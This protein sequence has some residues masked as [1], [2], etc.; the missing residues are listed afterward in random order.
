MQFANELRVLPNAL[1]Q[2]IWAAS[3]NSA[4]LWG[5]QV[6]TE[7][8]FFSTLASWGAG[9]PYLHGSAKRLLFVRLLSALNRPI[10][11]LARVETLVDELRGAAVSA[12]QFREAVE[13]ALSPSSLER[14]RFFLQL[15]ETY[16]KE[17][18]VRPDLDRA[19]RLAARKL[20]EGEVSV[21]SDRASI[22]FAPLQRLSWHKTVVLDALAR[23]LAPREVRIEVPHWETQRMEEPGAYSR[24][25][26]AAQPASDLLLGRLE[27]L[28]ERAAL[29]VLPA[30][31]EARPT[32]R[33]VTTHQPQSERVQV[34]NKLR[35][36]LAAGTPPHRI[37]VLVPDAANLPLWEQTMARAGVR[38]V[39][40]QK[41]LAHTAWGSWFLCLIDT[42]ARSAPARD[43]VLTVLES[44]F[45]EGVFAGARTS[46]GLLRRAH[47]RGHAPLAWDVMRAEDASNGALDALADL[48]TDFRQARS[49]AE[50]HAWLDRLISLLA[51]APAVR[52]RQDWLAVLCGDDAL[53]A[54]GLQEHALVLKSVGKVID[55]FGLEISSA[56]ERSVMEV[57]SDAIYAWLTAELEAA[58]LPRVNTERGVHVVTISELP[59][60][61]VDLLIATGL[62]DDDFPGTLAEESLLSR[63][64]RAEIGR[65]LATKHKGALWLFD[66]ASH[67]GEPAGHTVELARRLGALLVATNF[68]REALWSR[69]RADWEG[70]SL[71]PSRIWHAV[72]TYDV[73]DADLPS[74]ARA[75]D[76]GAQLRAEREKK[77]LKAMLH[78][79]TPFERDSVPARTSTPLHFSAS[80]LEDVVACRFRYF[81]KHVLRV[82]D[83]E[84]A[85]EDL[86]R[87]FSGQLAHAAFERLVRLL[88]QQGCVPFEPARAQ[89]AIEIASAS[90]DEILGNLDLGPAAGRVYQETALLRQRLLALVTA[91]YD[92]GEGFSPEWVEQSFGYD[93]ENSW[94]ALHVRTSAGDAFVRGRIDLVERRGDSFRVTDLKSSGVGTLDSK[95]GPKIGERELQLPIYCA[96]TAEHFG[97]RDIDGR[98]LSLRDSGITR[99]LRKK[100]GRGR[101]RG[102]DVDERVLMRNADG[103]ETELAANLQS[104]VGHV[105]RAD[106]RVHPL[107]GACDF[108]DYAAACRFPRGA[109]SREEGSS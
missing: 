26:H 66:L 55:A 103:E 46:A 17:C 63:S 5:Q 97:T 61:E 59:S 57:D 81:C 95:L 31:V 107:E 68:A 79:E 88:I 16:E 34:L 11:D 72:E 78:P 52:R 25:T 49:L 80:S 29:H 18:E 28:G 45:C 74:L 58:V 30:L 56:Q 43:S 83:D 108:C 32:V 38:I 35:A 36:A 102:V 47:Y 8:A 42:L 96:V 19:L 84:D 39:P 69:S 106:F 92:R 105:Q 27:A 12:R 101:G 53:G 24:S 77:S 93:D 104:L 33:A 41:R 51:T 21:F 94:P 23:A 44:V 22:S 89:D 13:L 86:D 48:S 75:L 98:L 50:W 82:R 70:R 14:L 73:T 4:C 10:S 62:V 60:A 67:P 65:A 109:P 40:P 64:E 15:Y 87:R 3:S 37:V 76:S 91:L 6:I 100:H 85:S 7:R 9:G 90:L 54:R 99:T 1:S 2:N 20:G 71:E